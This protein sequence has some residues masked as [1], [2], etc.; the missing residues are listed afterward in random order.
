[1][2]VSV[3]RFPDTSFVIAALGGKLRVM[4]TDEPSGA[5]LP[6][7]RPIESHPNHVVPSGPVAALSRI[8][9]S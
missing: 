6:V 8:T 7:D 9:P 2:Y 1:M 4:L 3:H 5:S